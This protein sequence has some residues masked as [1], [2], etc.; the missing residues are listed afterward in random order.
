MVH[1][2]RGMCVCTAV[3]GAVHTFPA[4]A[5]A[6]LEVYPAILPA[7]GSVSCGGGGL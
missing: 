1:A 4:C 2:D 7:F 6:A 3:K 5:L